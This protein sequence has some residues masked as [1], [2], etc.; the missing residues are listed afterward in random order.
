MTEQTKLVS[1]LLASHFKIS[2]QL[3]HSTEAEQEYMLQVLYS[4]PVGSL[5][6]TMVC[7]RPDISYVVGIVSKYMHNPSKGHWQ[8]VKWIIR[9]IRRPWMLV[10]YL[11]KM[12]HLVK[13]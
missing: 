10:Y 6:Y 4:S 5:M 8:A 13:V 1:T 3:S 12:I 11:S 9:Y 7:T 2:A